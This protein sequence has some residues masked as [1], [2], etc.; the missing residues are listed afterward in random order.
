MKIKSWLLSFVERYGY[1]QAFVCLVL[2]LILILFS[3]CS[4]VGPNVGDPAEK[5]IKSEYDK[6]SYRSLILQNRM[7]VL[8]ISDPETD[9]A[10]AALDIAVGQFSD[11][12]DRQGFAHYLEHMLFL[13]TD[14]Y[15]DA[16]AYGKFLSTHGGFSNAFTGFEDTN[17]FFSIHKDYLEGALDRFSQFFIS[18]RFNADYAEREINAVD[19]EHQKNLNNDSRR[20]YQILRNTANPKHPFH[21]FGTGNLASLRGG[22]SDDGKLRE[23]LIEFYRN[24]YSANLM[25]LVILGKESLDD[26]E[27]MARTHFSTV[28]DRDIKPD[29]FTD[30]PVI[31]RPLGRRINIRPIK[32][33]RQLKLMFPIPPQR[34]NYQY[35]TTDLITHLLGDEGKGSILAL[36]KK[37]GLA[38]SLSAGV[39]PESREFSFININISLTPEGLQKRDKIV[40]YVFQYFERIRQEPDLERYFNESRKI[41]ITNF[42]FREKEEPANYVSRLAMNMQD[43]SIQ[44][45]LISPWLYQSYQ[46][47]RSRNLLKYL[48]L[49][50]MQLVLIAEDLPVDKVDPW[51]GTRYSIE[52]IPADQLSLWRDPEPHQALALPPA[53][54][55]IVDNV[56]FQP[57]QS[58]RKYP[59]LLKH[60]DRI[61]VWFKQ[62]NIFKIPKGNLRIRL[63]TLDAYSSV[64]RAAMTKLFVLLLREHLNEYSYPA[65]VAGLHYSISNS[66]K[67]IELNLSGYSDNLEILFRKVV[68]EIK[69]YKIDKRRFKV[70]KDQ[71][72]ENRRNMKLSQAVRQ[73]GYEM[74]HLLSKP[75]WHTDE[76]LEVIDSITVQD[77]AAFVPTL[78]SRLHI[79]FLGH[80][81]FNDTEILE[82]ATF[83]EESFGS[84]E[85]VERPVERTLIVPASDP[86]VYQFPV[87]DVNSAIEIYFQAG[88]ETIKQSVSLDM[89][90][91]MVEKPFYHQLRT[92]EQLGYIVWSGYRQ[93]GKVDGFVFIIQSNVK[94]P[95]YVQSRIESFIT[96]FA[97]QLDRISEEE[98]MK[99]K[100]ALIAKRLEMPKNL[101]EETHRFWRAISSGSYDFDRRNSEIKA[102]Q[103]L[104]LADVKMLFKRVFITPENVKKVTGQAVGRVHQKV[105]PHERVILDPKKFKREREFYPNPEG[106]ISAKQD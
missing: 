29:R 34:S 53:N 79:D 87:E 64:K 11:P 60:T 37:Q 41:A 28:P 43:V 50:N 39:G 17:Y 89:I 75:F 93:T 86:M 78:F 54:P 85:P 57:S 4:V 22:S 98:F 67:G 36:L 76:Y 80:G 13:G 30:I 12:P 55:F 45:V 7:Q 8:L 63:S 16:D 10:A 32:S 96:S 95:T 21:M 88:P 61:R 56:S 46:A 83:L 52:R 68:E 3:G 91:Q 24:H 51:Y 2:P 100:E 103:K 15:P 31:E 90:Q 62:D 33:S 97:Q 99:Y 14:K 59:V 74:H 48:T 26:L 66:V 9:Q 65:L 71:M 73:I 25:K 69:R 84:R 106:T 20:I 47:E 40:G 72:A 81:N 27:K 6:R 19:S 35:K 44:H 49:E 102:L 58:K 5:I 1:R 42:R 104:S 18:P 92:V 70:L 38:T 82:L 23:Q 94:E 105:Q 101:Q 77:L